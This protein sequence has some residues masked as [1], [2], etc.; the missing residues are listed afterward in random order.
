M[1]AARA[2][3]GAAGVFGG[4]A[5]AFSAMTMAAAHPQGPAGR[6]RRGWPEPDAEARQQV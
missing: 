4:G 6:F 3:V 1:T 2:Q 5:M